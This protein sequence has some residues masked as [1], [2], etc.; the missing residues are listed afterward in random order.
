MLESNF[1]IAKC[2]FT[3]TLLAYSVEAIQFDCNFKMMNPLPGYRYSCEAVVIDSGS[4]SLENVTGVHLADKS[5]E[6]VVYLRIVNQYLE[7]VPEGIADFFINLEALTIQ[8]SSL[9]TISANDLKP[10]PRLV[11]LYLFRNELTTIDGDL[12][13]YTPHLRYASFELNRIQHIGYDLVSNLNNL[14]ELW[15]TG[16]VCI[17]LH[18]SN[19]DVVLLLAS[20]LSVLCPPLDDTTTGATTTSDATTTTTDRNIEPCMCDK[21]IEE[22]HKLNLGLEIQIFNLQASSIDQ[23]RK[24]EKLSKEIHQQNEVITQLKQSLVQDANF[25]EKR[26]LEVEMKLSETGSV[27]CFNKV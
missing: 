13:K 24:I 10:F 23:T 16:N 1:F 6:D 17:D 14:T 12:F 25:F 21:E 7:F 22:L 3:A 8:V 11:F 27:P 26:L 9:R 4:A 5:N 18:A 2:L 15:L 19:R 20:R